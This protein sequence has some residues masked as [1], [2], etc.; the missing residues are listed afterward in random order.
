VREEERWSTALL[1][2]E[3]QLSEQAL[4]LATAR[5]LAET[6]NRARGDF[7]AKMNHELRTL[8]NAVLGFSE[9]LKRNCS[10]KHFPRRDDGYRKVAETG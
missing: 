7:L 8:L 3:T 10:A 1:V 9:I 2:R 6:A 5:D 4:G